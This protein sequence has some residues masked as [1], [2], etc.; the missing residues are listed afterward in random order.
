MIMD[1]N[2]FDIVSYYIISKNHFSLINNL[3]NVSIKFKKII[4]NDKLFVRKKYAYI[5]NNVLNQFDLTL[6]ELWELIENK[7]DYKY[8]LNCIFNI[9]TKNDFT[10][11]KHDYVNKFNKYDKLNPLKNL[12]LFKYYQIK[13]RIEKSILLNMAL[14]HADYFYSIKKA[15]EIDDYC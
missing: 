13:Q 1:Y 9:Y 2:I 7:S 12:P 14:I 5:L 15:K 8:I 3:R 11:Y 6:D 4:D 10:Y